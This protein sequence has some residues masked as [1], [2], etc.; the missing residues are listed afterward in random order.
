MSGSLFDAASPEN[1]GKP[2]IYI[3]DELKHSTVYTESYAIARYG[4]FWMDYMF[5]MKDNIDDTEQDNE[6]T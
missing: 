6:G 3:F 1:N 5:T 2:T 4:A